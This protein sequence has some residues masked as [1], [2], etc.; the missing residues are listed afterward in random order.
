MGKLRLY[1]LAK[2]LNMSSPELM[3]KLAEGGQDYKNHFVQVDEVEVMAVLEKGE[4]RTEPAQEGAASKKAK[5]VKKKEEKADKAVQEEKEGKRDKVIEEKKE[6][7]SKG[8]LE[9]PEG[10]TVRE[11]AELVRASP[12]EIIKE[13]MKLGEFITITQSMSPEAITIMGEVFGYEVELTTPFQEVV[14]EEKVG[15]VE[16]KPRP[17]VVTVMGHVDHGKTTLLDT[18]RQT[19]VAVR[20]HGGIT[21]HIGAY[22]VFH[23]DK[24]ITFIDTPG[25]EAFTAMRA[26]GAQVTDLAVLVVAA[27]DGVK[28]QTIEALNHAKAAGVPVVVAINKIDKPE[29]NVDRVKQQ[30]TEQGL[31]PEEWGGET[32]FVAI[33]AKTG[34][35]IE[36]L[37]DVILLVAELQELKAPREARARGVVIEA[38]L[39]RGRGPVATVLVEKGILK[40]G[41]AVVVDLAYGKV[42]AVMDDK[43]DLINEA[44]PAQPVEIVG[45]SA[46]PAAGSELV[47]VEDEKAAR[48]IAEERML[49]VRLVEAGRRS[50]ISLEELFRRAQEGKMQELKIVLK[51]DTKGSIEAVQEALYGLDQE[52]VRVKIIHA[53]VGGITEADIMLAAA[54]EAIAVGFN[55]RPDSKARSQAI[56]EQVEVRTYRVIYQ[57]TEDIKAALKGMLA[58]EYVEE[59]LGRVEVRQVF[60]ISKVGSVAGCYVTEGKVTRSA[61]VRL[62]R[63]GSIVYEG[64][65]ASLKR[66]K[67]DVKE[68]K[69]GYECG[70]MLADFQDLKPG[71]I[72]EA[73]TLVEK[74]PS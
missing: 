55:V 4:V 73:Y 20:E 69:A 54:S 41:D 28:P 10:I 45:L 61:K 74:K 15:E 59:E 50:H 44:P 34:E 51:A 64:E 46:V 60:K 38:K 71:D 12:T 72:I 27:D 30:L 70:I 21:Q 53:A 67:D 16:A 22:Q 2:K 11:F 52:K 6:A 33:S 68:V 26:R 9:V 62:L 66:F 8:K 49:K 1:E 25:H 17:P 39:D 48:R 7:V 23:G 63:E 29:A 47:V 37:L 36:D 5:K 43:G 35:N 32:P 40:V 58:P 3:K 19:D 42:R 57:L 18:V 24:A 65:I 31:V 56:Q 14:L 13:L